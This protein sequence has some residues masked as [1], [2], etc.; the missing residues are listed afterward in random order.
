MRAMVLRGRALKVEDVELPRPGPMQVLAKVLACGI[1]G[2]DLHAAKFMDDMVAASKMSGVTSWDNADQDAG[3]VMGHE[4]VAEVV[5]AGT[6]AEAW[7]PGTRVTSVPVL[8]EPSSP[9]GF[10][11]IGYSTR[12]PGAYGQYVVLSAPML[13]K[14][15]DGLENIKGATTEP[16]AVGLH[17]VRQAAMQPGEH[18]VVMG[19]GPIGLM[20]LLWLKQ[21]GVQHVTVSDFAPSRRELA[22]KLGA[23]LVVDPA[24]TNLAEAV[25]A[26]AG[27]AAP[28]VFECVGVEGTLRQ[29]MELVERAGRVIVVGVCMKEDR[30]YP[31]VGINKHLTMKFVLGYSP[32]EYAESLAALGSGAIDTSP[33]VTRTVTLDELP[34]AF[35]ALADPSDCKIV[36]LPN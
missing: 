2:S 5:E 33:M 25:V 22:A 13:L 11:A 32:E 30:I 14:V 12:F 7:A 29:A 20:T 34:A 27:R 35:E 8:I 1:C 9:S 31:M 28:V 3:M 18:A 19:A 26:A 21:E 6:G 16:C 17:A 36:V 10:V 23:D 15:P 24:A 4:F